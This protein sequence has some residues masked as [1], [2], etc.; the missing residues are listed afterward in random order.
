M[1]TEI[2]PFEE[3]RREQVEAF[4]AAVEAATTYAASQQ[5]DAGRWLDGGLPETPQVT[6]P[7]PRQG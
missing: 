7:D 4:A 3:V 1:A 6:R 2:R 5:V